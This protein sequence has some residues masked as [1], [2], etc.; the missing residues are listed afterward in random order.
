MDGDEKATWRVLR[1]S[2]LPYWLGNRTRTLSLEPD[3]HVREGAMTP[4]C[5]RVPGGRKG[6]QYLTYV[7]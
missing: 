7:L 4:L 6:E 3:W 1:P 5:V 2:Q